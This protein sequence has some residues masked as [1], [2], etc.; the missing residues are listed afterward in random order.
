MVKIHDKEF[1]NLPWAVQ[2]IV[3]RDLETFGKHDDLVK[4]LL[5]EIRDH[6]AEEKVDIT[7]GD[8][9]NVL[10]YYRAGI[11]IACRLESVRKALCSD[12][13]EKVIDFFCSEEE[14]EV[15]E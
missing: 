15:S 14:E 7:Y 5:T 9:D 3:F 10:E 12:E 1:V 13:L 6:D 4:K 2:K 8:L 11:D